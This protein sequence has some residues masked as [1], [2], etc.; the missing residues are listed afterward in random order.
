[1]NMGQMMLA[2]MAM[3]LLGLIILSANSSLLDNEQVVM[4]SEFGVASI[5]LATSLMEEVLG[6]AFDEACADTTVG[7]IN[8][9]TPII[10]LGPDASE[11]YRSTD[12]SSTDFDDVDDFQSFW[13]EFVA[14]TSKPKI[15]TYR[16]NARGFRADYFVK[17]KVEYVTAGSGVAILDGSAGAR[18]WHKKLTVT[19]TSPS[20]TDTL[21]FP[22]II[23]YWD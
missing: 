13:I 11:V 19:V 6:K 23:S 9:L 8:D 7:T 18:T 4:D 16:G 14:D 3:S 15:A 1:M 2:V 5:S 12:S 10:S 21:V 20:S 22:T 17:S